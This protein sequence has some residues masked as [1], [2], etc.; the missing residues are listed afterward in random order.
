MF[1]KIF[2]K[3]FF[4]DSLTS[5]AE[6]IR[7]LNDEIDKKCR[8]LND[9]NVKVKKYEKLAEKVREDVVVKV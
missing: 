4:S 2:F 9:V 8:Q 5:D 7:L 3:E 1:T 6:T